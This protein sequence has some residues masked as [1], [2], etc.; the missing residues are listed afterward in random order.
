MN[1][2]KLTPGNITD[3]T[4]DGNDNIDNSGYYWF[5]DYYQDLNQAVPDIDISLRFLVFRCKMQV[6]Q[7]KQSEEGCGIT[8][9]QDAHTPV[10]LL[11]VWEESRERTE[12]WGGED[13]GL[14][15]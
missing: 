15:V 6:I 7:Q 4:A 3:M 12:V 10:L 5:Y 14:S 1:D 9:Q 2:G 8:Q 13:E 11:K